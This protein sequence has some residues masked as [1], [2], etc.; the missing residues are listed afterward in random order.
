MLVSFTSHCMSSVIMSEHR[1]E[2]RG[3]GFWRSV[4]PFG[5]EQ[6]VEPITQAFYEFDQALMTVRALHHAA[7]MRPQDRR[8]LL[9]LRDEMIDTEL[10]SLLTNHYPLLNDT[11]PGSKTLSFSGGWKDDGRYQLSM[12]SAAR[13]NS[14]NRMGELS[15]DF[16]LSKGTLS[17]DSA[18]LTSQLSVSMGTLLF[19]EMLDSWEVFHRELEWSA[20]P[21]P[22][23]GTPLHA[24]FTDNGM[25]FD[26][27][28]QRILDK[29]SDSAP[30]LLA[31]IR[32]LTDIRNIVDTPTDKFGPSITQINLRQT[33][34]LD[35]LKAHY[36]Q[37]YEQYAVIFEHLS[38]ST[39]IV[40]A[41]GKQ[42]AAV[43]YN[44][45]TKMFNVK[46]TVSDGGI[47]LTDQSETPTAEIIYPTKIKTL[48]YTVSNDIF[49]N[50][51]GLKIYIDQLT[52]NSQYTRNTLADSEQTEMTMVLNQLPNVRVEG[53]LLHFVPPW[54]I[55]ALIPGTIE[56]AIAE[57]FS[58]AVKGR[59]GQG[60]VITFRS[61]EGEGQHQLSVGLSTE[62]RYQLLQDV[63]A[64]IEGSDADANVEEQP[65][66]FK[67]L[68]EAL[69]KDFN[70][71]LHRQNIRTI[72]MAEMFPA[73]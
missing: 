55:D 34:K 66:I 39:R 50:I 56:S 58:E 10:E 6:N 28:D 46:M 45:E 69:R 18:V 29:I 43:H 23:P 7:Q 3:L 70:A 14:A 57:A 35:I 27:N 32:R 4:M 40:T 71:L 62:L 53:A 1:A 5:S 22:T 48:D 31:L 25:L 49:V 9:V 37:A 42:I 54:L 24:S 15:A 60:A 26:R 63:A 72:G 21:E 67:D 19:R 52:M 36:T 41:Q 61:N 64:N 68:G 2:V 73:R 11:A 8:Q 59:G 16:T 47:V 12:G 33:I 38:F 65:L 51:F 20:K 13:F 44:A 30:T 17:N